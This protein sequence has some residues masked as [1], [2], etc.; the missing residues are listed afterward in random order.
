M[1]LVTYQIARLTPQPET[2][3]PRR[4]RRRASAPS[5]D[6]LCGMKAVGDKLGLSVDRVK[7]LMEE[8]RLEYIRIGRR[9]YFRRE[10]VTRLGRSSAIG[11]R[12]T[13]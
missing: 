6:F 3:K 4:R 11:K 10:S 1:P 9:H 12:K 5:G 2:A 13:A 7:T 8:G